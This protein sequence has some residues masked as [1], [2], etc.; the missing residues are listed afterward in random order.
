MCADRNAE[1]LAGAS[2]GGLRNHNERLLLSLIREMAPVPASDLA[3]QVN[4]S[5]QTVS[6]IVRDLERDGYIARGAPKRGKVGKPSVPMSIA[7]DGAYSIG[8][9]VG[10]RS[11]NLAL[12]DFH[13]TVRAQRHLGYSYPRVKEILS[14]LRAGIEAFTS[15]IPQTHRSRICGIGLALPFEIWKWADD[16]GAPAV[17]ID[18]WRDVDLAAEIATFS[19]LP[20]FV[21]ND[22]T[23]ACRAEQNFGA[24]RQ[25]LD[26]AY[27]FVGAFI[28]GGVVLNGEVLDGNRG[29]AGAL[30]SLQAVDQAGRSVQLIDRASLHLLE[31]DLVA[32]GFDPKDLWEQDDWSRYETQVG[33]WIER[34]APEIARASLS[35]CAVLDFEAVMIDG[36]FPEAI[37]TRLVGSV[38]E[39]LSTLDARGVL[40]PKVVEGQ[41]GKN[42][43]VLGAAFSPISSEFFLS[44]AIRWPTS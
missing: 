6:V 8:L 16:I 14:F 10:R 2:Q 37:R 44:S 34:A 29:N 38:R 1:V 24:G 33:R 11:A 41:V 23:A 39:T 19:A 13:G 42:A 43:R 30:G 5:A 26:Y 36:A 28:G 9:K 35:A 12:M 40:R 17:E 15:S 27:F 22:A 18:E 25:F 21:M 31:Q 4:L 7:G 3:R 20:L 32:A